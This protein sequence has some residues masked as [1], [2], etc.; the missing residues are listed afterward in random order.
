MVYI[1]GSND[2]VE[3]WSSFLD[4]KIQGIMIFNVYK[5]NISPCISV[6]VIFNVNKENLT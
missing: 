4:M 1:L 2:L 3:A 6:I 5:G